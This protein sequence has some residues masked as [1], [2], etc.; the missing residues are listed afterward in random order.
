MTL[1]RAFSA[2]AY[3]TTATDVSQCVQRA[4]WF[5]TSGAAFIPSR[6]DLPA[7]IVGEDAF[8]SP[9]LA[10]FVDLALAGRST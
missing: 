9:D 5:K 8:G 1:V 2:S 3:Q 7:F 4:R 10:L 6:N